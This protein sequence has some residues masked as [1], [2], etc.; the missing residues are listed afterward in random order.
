[1]MTQTPAKI[2]EPELA[3]LRFFKLVS[4]KCDFRFVNAQIPTTVPPDHFRLIAR[5]ILNTDTVKVV[6]YHIETANEHWR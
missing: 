5:S 1:M 4:F 3:R 6:T 2:G